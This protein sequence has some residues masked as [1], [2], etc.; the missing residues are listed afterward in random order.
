MFTRLL[1]Q[2]TLAVMA[3]TAH[4]ASIDVS[5]IKGHI[6]LDKPAERVVVLTH[7]ALDMLDF[8]EVTPVGAVHML[9][10]SYLAHYGETVT[11][12]G[13]LFEPDFETL[14]TLKPDLIIADERMMRI[15]DDLNEVAPT[16]MLSTTNGQYWHDTQVNW[17]AIATLVGKE[18]KMAS[19]IK[20][21]QQ[22]LEAIQSAVRAEK[23]DAMMVM[24]S[25]KKLST[26]EPQSRF[27]IIFEE[28]GFLPASSQTVASE[29]GPHGKLISF[30]YIADAKPSTLFVLDREQAT[31]KAHGAAQQLFDN[32][33]IA[34]TPAAKAQ[35]IVYVDPVAWYLAYGGVH[36]TEIMMDDVA[37]SLDN[38]PH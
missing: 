29:T 21:T 22:R 37:S 6:E 12:V 8:L 20:E 36:A 11:N 10:P 28:F 3:Y 35:R 33:L 4:A 1:F 26:F 31:G 23:R 9:M 16:L 5:H 18:D 19:K 17:R 14:F 24:S 30:E 7:S 32:P 13:S 38:S 25:G 27:S 34:H 2:F 15:Y